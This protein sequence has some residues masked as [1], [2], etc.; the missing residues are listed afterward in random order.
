MDDKKKGNIKIDEK[1]DI[2]INID[3]GLGKLFG[4]LKDIM[5]TVSDLSGGEIKREGTLSETGGKVKG[6]YGF[7]VR[8]LDGS[9]SIEEFGNKIKKD[10][11]DGEVFIDSTREPIVD[12]MDEGATYTVIAEIPGV[13]EDDIKVIIN[14]DIVQISAKSTTREYEKELLFKSEVEQE[15]IKKSYVN[16]MLELSLKKLI[17]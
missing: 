16:G 11:K 14:G 5:N 4:G 2:N 3:F 8:T 13:S 10:E 9:T 1:G 15:P 17:K 12:I 7:T 6:I